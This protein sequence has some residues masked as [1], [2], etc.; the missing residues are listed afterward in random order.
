M[1]IHSNVCMYM[2]G[3]YTSATMSETIRLRHQIAY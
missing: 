2:Q 1:F 3:R